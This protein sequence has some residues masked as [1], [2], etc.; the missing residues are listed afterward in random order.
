MRAAGRKNARCWPVVRMLEGLRAGSPAGLAELWSEFPLVALCARVCLR[1]RAP[2]RCFLIHSVSLKQCDELKNGWSSFPASGHCS[3]GWAISVV[4]RMKNPE[5]LGS[6]TVAACRRQ[7]CGIFLSCSL[8]LLFM[9]SLQVPSEGA[10]RV[11]ADFC[12]EI[13]WRKEKWPAKFLMSTCRLFL[14]VLDFLC[15]VQQLK[16]K[17]KK[18]LKIFLCLQWQF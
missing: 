17:K 7:N 2:A 8:C 18:F 4:L 6:S 13:W 1:G 14:M 11:C 9:I 5:F 15:L 10:T 16:A 3:P 12:L